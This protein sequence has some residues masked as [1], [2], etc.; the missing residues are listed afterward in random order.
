[1]D[2]MISILIVDDNLHFG[3]LLKERMGS[4]ADLKVVGVAGDGLQAI[5]MIK[6]LALDIVV[7]DVIMPKLD[8]IGVLER[9]SE[10]ELDTKPQFIM[11]TAIG[12]DLYIQKAIELGAEYYMVKPFNMDV[13]VSRVRQVHHERLFGSISNKKIVGP[14][15]VSNRCNQKDDFE[16]E[17]TNLM[18]CMGIRPDIAGYQYIRDA[19]LLIM[20]N[21]KRFTSYTK[22]LYPSIALKYNASPQ[23]VERGI[24]KAIETMW[25]HGN[26]DSVD[27]LF[28]YTVSFSKGKPTNAE[29]IAMMV[30]KI[31]VSRET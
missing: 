29:F 4:E 5:D 9:V 30:D 6:S 16:T 8:G 14:D 11:L 23:K 21:V 7:L 15:K 25:L 12:Q 31:R 24:R 17:V 10:L 3:A 19:I 18:Q 27:S 28:G 1:M 2:D 13:L 26:R 22:D 20:G